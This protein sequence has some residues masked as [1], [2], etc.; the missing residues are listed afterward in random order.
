[1]E[2]RSSPSSVDI[3]FIGVLQIVYITLKLIGHISWSWWQVLL[4]LLIFAG[5]VAIRLLV[6]SAALI[7]DTFKR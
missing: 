4:P 3:G 5:I 1:M 7:Y 2:T 6:L